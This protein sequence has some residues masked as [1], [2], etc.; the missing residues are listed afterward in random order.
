MG[1]NSRAGIQAIP[2]G[3]MEAALALGM[4]RRQA[5]VKII[6][7]AIG[8]EFIALLKVSSLVSVQALSDY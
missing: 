1:E 3:K 7:P 2:K 5:M 6:F 4:S 8:N